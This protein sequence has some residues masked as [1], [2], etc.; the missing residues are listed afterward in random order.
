MTDPYAFLS[1]LRVFWFST[2]K[3]YAPLPPFLGNL[4]KHWLYTSAYSMINQ[5]YNF[6]C[7]RTDDA[8]IPNLKYRIILHF[9]KSSQLLVDVFEEK[10]DSNTG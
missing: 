2:V 8:Y 7:Q 1:K 5:L 6:N 4:M 9:L 3:L 10:H